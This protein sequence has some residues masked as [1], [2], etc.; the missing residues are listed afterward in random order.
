MRRARPEGV[1]SGVDMAAAWSVECASEARRGEGGRERDG[2][3]GARARASGTRRA[4]GDARRPRPSAD[5]GATDERRGP[6]P[7]GPPSKR[8]Y[9]NA[10]GGALDTDAHAPPTLNGHARIGRARDV[11]QL[12]RRFPALPVFPLSRSKLFP[13]TIVYL[14]C[15]LSY[16]VLHKTHISMKR[17]G[18]RHRER[19][20]SASER[21]GRNRPSAR[22]G[23]LRHKNRTFVHMRRAALV[24]NF[25]LCTVFDKIIE[26]NR[27]RTKL[28]LL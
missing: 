1:R 15:F 9:S 2:E 24:P 27:S 25:R 11:A 20:D 5:T 21:L 22:F 28:T 3:R 19:T 6:A 17:F 26:K 10:A 18:K 14:Y 12:Q 7:R 8:P 23:S 16:E 4:G 13:P